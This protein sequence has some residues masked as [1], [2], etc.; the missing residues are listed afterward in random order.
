MGGED[1]CYRGFDPL[2]PGR[3]LLTGFHGDKIWGLYEKPNTVL[4]R[5]DVSG[6]CL[7]EFR[8]W[9]DFMHIPVPMIGA[10]RHPEIAALSHA[11]G[12]RPYLLHNDYDRPIP[13]RVLEQAGVPRSLFGQHKKAASLQLFLDKRLLS[14]AARRECEASVPKQW[15]RA[16]KHSPAWASWKLRYWGYQQLRRHGRRIPGSEPLRR[17]LVGDARVFQHGHP[18]AALGFLAGLLVVAR[19]Y[20]TVLQRRGVS[21]LPAGTESPCMRGGSKQG[22]Q[23]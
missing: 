8:L 10:R 22:R 18:R 9:R 13:R 7:Q 12:M 16:A 20:Q 11:P 2:L 4:A 6:S 5:G 23:T 15:V 19:R 1:Y 21:R 17:A 3:V 14:P